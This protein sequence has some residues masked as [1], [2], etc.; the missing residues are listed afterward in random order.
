[1]NGKFVVKLP[2]KQLAIQQLGDSRGAALKRFHSLER[3]FYKQPILKQEYAKFM[4]EYLELGNMTMISEEDVAS[5]GFWLPYHSVIR[6][7]SLTTKL[8]VVFHPSSK[9]SSNIPLNDVLIVGPTL[10]E[11]LFSFNLPFRTHK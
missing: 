5:P 7:G 11:G 10:Q 3:K 2:F 9:S 1:M 8:C 6:E 4:R